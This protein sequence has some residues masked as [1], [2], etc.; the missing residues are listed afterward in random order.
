MTPPSKGATAVILGLGIDLCSVRRMAHFVQNSRFLEKTFV[1][2]ER[3]YAF[4]RKEPA[5]HLASAFATK[6]A[7]AKAGRWGLA[8][9]GLRRVWLSHTPEGIPEVRWAGDLFSGEMG[10]RPDEVWVSISHDGDVAVALVVLERTA[11]AA[12]L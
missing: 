9:V 8:K 4:S 11:H 2:E 10:P 1:E 7:F 12:P 6:E 5:R 3:A